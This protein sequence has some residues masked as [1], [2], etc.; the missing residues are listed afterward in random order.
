MRHVPS[1]CRRRPPRGHRPKVRCRVRRCPWPGGRHTTLDDLRSRRPR[2]RAAVGRRDDRVVPHDA[3]H[4]L[5]VGRRLGHAPRASR[6]PS[7]AR[8]DRASQPT[9]TFRRS[10]GSWSSGSATSAAS[11]SSTRPCGSARSASSPRSPRRKGPSR[12]SSPSSSGSGSSAGAALTLA[13][14]AVGIAL[15]AVHRDEIA[16]DWIRRG[17]CAPRGPPRRSAPRRVFARR[18]LR[19]GPRQRAPAADLGG[20]ARAR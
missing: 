5:G 6:S 8:P 17:R 13:V 2:R 15:A 3:R 4:R 18:P 16:L 7:R 11:S 14:I 10:A 12:R 20:A 1:S 19:R 9:S